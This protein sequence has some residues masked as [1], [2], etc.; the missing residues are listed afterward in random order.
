MLDGQTISLELE[1]REIGRIIGM[2]MTREQDY[3][4]KAARNG[5]PD[6]KKIKEADFTAGIIAKL[7]AATAA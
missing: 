6:L 4:F 5:D 7:R 1:R 3:R 2:L